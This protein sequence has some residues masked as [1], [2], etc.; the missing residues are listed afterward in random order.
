METNRLF[1]NNNLWVERNDFEETLK[2]NDGIS[3]ANQLQSDNGHI[4]IMISNA[5]C[6]IEC[7]PNSDNAD[8]V[9]DSEKLT[10]KDHSYFDYMAKDQRSEQNVLG[11]QV[12]EQKE[13]MLK[14]MCKESKT[15]NNNVKEEMDEDLNIFNDSYGYSAT[16]PSNSTE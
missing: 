16:L 12:K 4:N 9:F 14:R 1:L 6:E 11:E 2:P 3:M 7:L 8:W 10:K 5:V 13:E 15:I